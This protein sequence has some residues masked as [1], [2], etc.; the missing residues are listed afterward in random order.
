M[1]PFH[2]L[3]VAIFKRNEIGC[4]QKSKNS[5][6]QWGVQCQVK[7][8]KT[9]LLHCYDTNSNNGDWYL[10]NLDTKA[11]RQTHVLGWIWRWCLNDKCLH[12]WGINHSLHKCCQIVKDNTVFEH[13]FYPKAK[14]NL[15]QLCK[16]LSGI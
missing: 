6:Y 4:V 9:W 1:D 5:Q 16:F 2:L 13:R 15:F 3:M 7:C 10:Q 14:W 12:H 11:P 8:S